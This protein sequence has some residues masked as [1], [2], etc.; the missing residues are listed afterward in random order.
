MHVPVSIRPAHEPDYTAIL[1]LNNEADP[2]VFQLTQATLQTLLTQA[3]LTWVAIMNDAVAGYL[4]GLA[5]TASYDGEEFGWFRTRGEGFLYV[6]QV[7][8]AADYRGKGIGTALY[9][10]L[11]AWARRHGWT[12]ITCEVH[13]APPNPESYAFHRRRGFAELERL[14]TSDGRRVALLHKELTG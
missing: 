11:E 8:V 6:D 1:A 10:S 7:V 3:T 5:C 9:S 14:D 13:L 12:S 4:I 2:R